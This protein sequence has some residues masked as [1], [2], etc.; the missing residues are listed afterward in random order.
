LGG[1]KKKGPDEGKEPNLKEKKRQE[2]SRGEKV[3]TSSK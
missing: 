1:Q 3:L 2:N